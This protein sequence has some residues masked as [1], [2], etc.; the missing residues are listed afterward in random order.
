MSNSEIQTSDP[1]TMYQN[2]NFPELILTLPPK[3]VCVFLSYL[4]PLLR[5]LSVI[6]DVYVFKILAV[7]FCL[8][9]SWDESLINSD[10]IFIIFL[11]WYLFFL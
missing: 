6:S 4:S 9:C 8:L 3:N 7:K 5:S 10:T 1:S 2:A 11:N